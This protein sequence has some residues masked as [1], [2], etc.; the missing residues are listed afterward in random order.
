MKSLCVLSDQKLFELRTFFGFKKKILHLGIQ[1]KWL[2]QKYL[3][4]EPT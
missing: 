3:S 4:F 1:M 2:F